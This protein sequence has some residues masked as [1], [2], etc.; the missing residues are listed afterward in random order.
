MRSSTRTRLRILGIS[1]AMWPVEK[2]YYEPIVVKN[3]SE[4]VNRDG[5]QRGKKKLRDWN[6]HGRGR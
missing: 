3:P 6:I 1:V 5:K 2:C 4:P